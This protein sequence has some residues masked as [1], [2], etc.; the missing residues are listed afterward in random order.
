[1]KVQVKRAHTIWRAS[2][3]ISSSFSEH[4]LIDKASAIISNA[5]EAAVDDFCSKTIA[6][7][8]VSSST[9]CMS[10]KHRICYQPPYYQTSESSYP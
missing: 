4:E 3:F 6:E 2:T 5:L 1:M 9:L 10:N 7:R 8:F